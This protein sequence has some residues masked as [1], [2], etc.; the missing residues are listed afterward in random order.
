MS[1]LEAEALS[2]TVMLGER[3]REGLGEVVVE[4]L[5]QRLWVPNEDTEAVME[6]EICER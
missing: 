2:T 4:A 3:E 6:K 1:L 5:G